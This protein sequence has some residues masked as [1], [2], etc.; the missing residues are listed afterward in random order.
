MNQNTMIPE[1][2]ICILTYNREKHLKNILSFARNEYNNL[3]DKL[4]VEII[5][6]DNCSTDGSKEIIEEFINKNELFEWRYNRNRK[7]LGLIGNLL[8]GE[9][10]ATG[11]YLWWWG[12]DDRYKPGI[13]SAVLDHI[14]SNP[15]YI[16]L[17]HSASRE[18]WD[19]HYFPSGL[20]LIKKL[21]LSIVDIIKYSPGCIM[22]IS[23]SIYRIEKLKKIHDIK[24]KI[25]LALPLL[26]GIYCAN[27]NNNVIDKRVW[28]DDNYKDISW[29]S[30]ASR[31]LYYDMPYYIS[32]MPKLGY[33]KH[34]S[35]SIYKCLYKGLRKKRLRYNLLTNLKIILEK[36]NCLG[37]AKKAKSLIIKK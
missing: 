6:S 20:D 1:L 29:G 3:R 19:C 24:Y 8:K 31:L 32:M 7:N 18:P 25:N 21:D 10:L 23:A 12:D 22:F 34:E 16:L 15:D 35:R 37:L 11:K 14:E 5:I 33:D 26:Y 4:K 13:I 30:E 27:A 28:I 17:N 2:S 36:I 9:E